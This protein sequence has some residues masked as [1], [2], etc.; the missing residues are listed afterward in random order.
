MY[1]T[2]E[3]LAAAARRWGEPRRLELEFAITPRERGVIHSTSQ[4]DRAH[5]VTFFI[6][7]D[8]RFA[9]IAKPFFPPGVWRAPSGGLLPGEDIET[10][11]KREALEE[12]GLEIELRHYL[13]RI[14]AR[15]TLDG[16]IEPWRTQVFLTRAASGDLAPR[17]T[18]EIRA[19]RWATREEIQGPIRAALLATGYPLFRYRVALTDATFERMDE[20]A[21]AR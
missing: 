12:T 8:G 16:E 7:H 9:V 4:P 6:E 15:F 3:L 10:G 20:V 2:E 17:D 1:V 14:E 19:A 13:L 21:A 5:D 18:R 11:A